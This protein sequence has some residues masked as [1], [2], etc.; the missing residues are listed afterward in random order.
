MREI[1]AAQHRQ[2]VVRFKEASARPEIPDQELTWRVHF[3]FGA[4]S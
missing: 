2:A 3:M 4:L 1:L